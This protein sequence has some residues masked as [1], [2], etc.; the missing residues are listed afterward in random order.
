[1][2]E[3]NRTVQSALKVVVCTLTQNCCS[4]AIIY[5]LGL[6][7]NNNSTLKKPSEKEE[8]ETFDLYIKHDKCRG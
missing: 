6:L 3:V 1:M 8:R 5:L 2:A 4:F 7:L